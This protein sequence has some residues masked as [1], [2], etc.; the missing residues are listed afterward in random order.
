[1]FRNLGK[2]WH[3]QQKLK[4]KIKIKKKEWRNNAQL[5]INFVGILI[6]LDKNFGK[7]RWKFFYMQLSNRLLQL[8]CIFNWANVKF[9]CK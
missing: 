1:M 3:K 8:H 6:Q 4:K 7:G 9:C 5:A 2:G